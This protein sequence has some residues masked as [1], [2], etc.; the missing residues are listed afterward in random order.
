MLMAATQTAVVCIARNILQFNLVEVVL[1]DRNMNMIVKG[2]VMQISLV[3]WNCPL[4][5]FLTPE[6][7]DISKCC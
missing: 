5:N 2:T 4:S 3:F 6:S 1:T 7:S